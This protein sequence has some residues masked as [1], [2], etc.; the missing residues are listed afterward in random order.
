MTT[1]NEQIIP[2]QIEEALLRLEHI[3]SEI[4]F[5]YNGDL[6]AIPYRDK[7]DYEAKLTTIFGVLIR[8]NCVLAYSFDNRGLFGSILTFQAHVKNRSF[9]TI[10][11]MIHLIAPGPTEAHNFNEFLKEVWKKVEKES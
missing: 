3:L 2:E 10:G 9:D 4:S 7:R 11:M 5:Q 1:A 6:V 8:E